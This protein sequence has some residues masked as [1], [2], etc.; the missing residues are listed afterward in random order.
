VKYLLLPFLLAIS[1]PCLAQSDYVQSDL[2]QAPDSVPAGATIVVQI[3]GDLPYEITP[4]PAGIIR[5]KDD[6]GNRVLLIQGAAS[7]GYEISV[8]YQVIHPTEEETKVAP[9]DD[10]EKFAAW[11]KETSRD[12]FFQDSHTVKVGGPGPRPP[13]PPGPGPQPLPDPISKAVFDAVVKLPDPPQTISQAHAMAKV[14]RTVASRAAGLSTMTV[15]EM[16]TAIKTETRNTFDPNTRAKW[17]PVGEVLNAL[18]QQHIRDR[19][20]AIETYNKFADGLEA[21]R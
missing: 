5:L 11:L 18:A 1:A 17:V 8:D 6:D 15:E 12:E 21:V 4:K 3:K 20:T 2:I 7:P 19:E 10:R 9:W 16:A 14:Y 13:D